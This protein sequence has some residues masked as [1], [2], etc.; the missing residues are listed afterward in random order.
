[1]ELGGRGGGKASRFRAS[2][3]RGSGV[4]GLGLRLVE[5]GVCTPDKAK[6]RGLHD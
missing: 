1:M 6:N 2:G 4:E 3:F 5:F